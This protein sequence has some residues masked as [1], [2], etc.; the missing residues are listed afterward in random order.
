M[1]PGEKSQLAMFL[2]L[3]LIALGACHSRPTGRNRL[4]E[5]PFPRTVLWAWERPEDLKALDPD[6]VAVAFLA[7][8]LVL[9]GDDVVT[10]ST[11]WLCHADARQVSDLPK[12]PLQAWRSTT[13]YGSKTL[14]RQKG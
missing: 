4:D 10:L 8:T 2:F 14:L 13:A 1:K 11:Q 7:Q 12:E 3:P 9:K 5:N 6:R